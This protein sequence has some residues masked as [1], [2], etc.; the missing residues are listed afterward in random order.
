MSQQTK[1][2]EEDLCKIYLRIK[3]LA[4]EKKVNLI[5]ILEKHR[6]K[7]VLSNRY[8]IM[9]S[10]TYDT[11]TMG[12]TFYTDIDLI[13]VEN[14]GNPFISIPLGK[15]ESYLDKAREILTSIE[16]TIPL[17]KTRNR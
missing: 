17:K 3:Y 15:Y 12:L 8:V 16:R 11:E 9:L 7:K 4:K 6:A 5:S 10:S 2:L 1:N 13:R 14:Y